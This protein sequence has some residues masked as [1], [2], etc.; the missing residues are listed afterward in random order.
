[1]QVNHPDHV[2]TT[3]VFSDVVDDAAMGSDANKDFQTFF[4]LF[5]ESTTREG[6]E[7]ATRKM[8]EIFRQSKNP[9]IIFGLDAF[10][11]S[12][13]FT[14]HTLSYVK[15]ASG[16]GGAA[17]NSTVAATLEALTDLDVTI[18]LAIEFSRVGSTNSVNIGGQKQTEVS[19]LIACGN[20]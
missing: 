17:F 2:S 8:K 1:M 18:G 4:K 6:N 3:S 20:R 13:N 16:G 15:G 5:K 14:N 19:I 11:A 12:V 9:R 7:A 10:R